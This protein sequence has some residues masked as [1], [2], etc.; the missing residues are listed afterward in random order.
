MEIRTQ[1]AISMTD[2]RGCGEDA[3]KIKLYSFSTWGTL[4][5]WSLQWQVRGNKKKI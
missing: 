2:E 3:E 5:T 4:T 1:S